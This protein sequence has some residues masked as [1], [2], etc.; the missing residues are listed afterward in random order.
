MEPKNKQDKVKRLRRGKKQN[1][2]KKTHEKHDKGG[3]LHLHTQFIH[4]SVSMATAERSRGGDGHFITSFTYAH[5][6]L[7]HK[8]NRANEQINITHIKS[9]PD[10]SQDPSSKTL[11]GFC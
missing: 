2:T 6:Y 9:S 11:L 8:N 3:Y 1:K 7:S 5:N 4:V 10:S